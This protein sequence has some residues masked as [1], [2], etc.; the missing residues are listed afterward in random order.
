LNRRALVGW[1]LAACW[2]IPAPAQFGG[3]GGPSILSRGGG[4]PGRSGGRPLSFRPFAGVSSGYFTGLT[5][6]DKLEETS[7]FGWLANFGAVLNTT[8]KRDFGS[9]DYRGNYTGLKD[10][11]TFGGNNHFLNANYGRQLS[12]HFTMF[13]STSASYI[14]YISGGAFNRFS[15][16]P[17]AQ[18]ASPSTN[19][20]DSKMFNLST[21]AGFTYQKSA[22]L[23]FS[24]SGF[25]FT[26]RF[27]DPRLVDTDGYGAQG[28]VSYYLSRHQSVGASYNYSSYTHKNSFGESYINNAMFTFARTVSPRWRVDL[29]GGLFQVESERLVQVKVD[30]VIA[31][32]TGQTAVIEAFHGTNHGVSANLEISGRFARSGVS[33][34]YHRGV[35]P[36]NG[37]Y[38]TSVQD[39]G[40]LSYSYTGIRYWN[41]GANSTYSRMNAINSGGT[42]T[43]VGVGGGATRRLTSVIH[44]VAQV[45]MLHSVNDS[46]AAFRHDRFMATVGI[47]FAPGDMPLPL[48]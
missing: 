36:G 11:S 1:L 18:L 12:P 3:F 38:L 5:S 21:A 27:K 45:N 24:G 40:T 41:I 34:S 33:L 48:F 7:E 46:R 30:P 35:S 8:G 29:A 17:T 6:R 42:F 25:G 9:L 32:I 26:S 16:N 10:A 37:A 43:Y 44:F 23:V 39:V 22:R 31:A 4:A 20:F 19:L 14:S 15:D 47:N 28:S 13:L 2:T